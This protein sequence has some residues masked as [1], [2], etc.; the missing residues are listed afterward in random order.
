MPEVSVIVPAYNHEPYLKQRL[1]SVFS[2]R[3]DNFEVIILDDHSSDNSVD[4]IKQYSHQPKLKK[5]DVNTRN[6]GSPFIQWQKGF[7]LAAGKYVWIAESDDWAE[8]DFLEKMVPLL[9][10]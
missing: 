1:D 5:I 9:K 2:Q 3:F 8:P 7:E 10:G 4:V 6:S